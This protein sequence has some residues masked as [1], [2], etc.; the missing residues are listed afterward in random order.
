MGNKEFY[1]ETQYKGTC[2]TTKGKEKTIKVPER[3]KKFT[4]KKA[5]VVY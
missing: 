5:I 1:T 4:F 3:K 2:K